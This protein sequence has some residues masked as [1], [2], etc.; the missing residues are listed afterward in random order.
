M[1]CILGLLSS[2]FFTAS[3]LSTPVVADPSPAAVVALNDQPVTPMRPTTRDLSVGPVH[4]ALST[5]PAIPAKLDTNE[6]YKIFAC[7]EVPHGSITGRVSSSTT[8]QMPKFGC[9]RPGGSG[10]GAG[11]DEG[12]GV[13]FN[14]G[15]CKNSVRSI[16]SLPW[17]RYCPNTPN[18]PW[19]TMTVQLANPA[20][21]SKM[22][23]GKLVTLKGDFFVLTK[24]N[25]SYLF[26]QNA[27][28]LYADPFGR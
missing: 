9:A 24:N 10:P 13:G 26:V 22:P 2:A 25:V 15:P 3:L 7:G 4:A 11:H 17:G 20:D 8:I 28:V 18:T 23:L 5:P 21:A 19:L 27:N 6:P 14:F 16:P 12:A 1:R